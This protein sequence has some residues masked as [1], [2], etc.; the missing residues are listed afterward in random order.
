MSTGGV[1]GAIGR[2]A[3]TAAILAAAA[4]GPLPPAAAAGPDP[5]PD[6]AAVASAEAE[7]EEACTAG[8]G[9]YQREMEGYLRRKADGVQDEGDCAAIRRFQQGNGVR[10]ADGYAGLATYRNMV[11]V[12]ARSNPNAARACPVRPHRVTCVDLERQ[13]LWVQRDSKV[14]F[15]PVPVRTGRDDQETR[16]GWHEVYWR[17]KD[18]KSTLYDDA[19]MPYAQFFDEGQALHGRPGNLYAH[20]GSAGCVNLSV[21]DAARLWDLLTEGDAVYVWGTKPGT[22][23]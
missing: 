18:H 2:A 21:P 20:G 5:V 15:A 16:T 4:L 17:S 22:E 10:P 19:P 1:A 9:P 13:L 6:S 7:A 3:L 11:A 12:A 8:T 14:V 23:G